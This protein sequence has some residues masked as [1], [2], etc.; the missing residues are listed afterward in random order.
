MSSNSI[1]KISS[2]KHKLLRTIQNFANFRSFSTVAVLRDAPAVLLPTATH[3]SIDRKWASHE[4]F[5]I[6]TNMMTAD[7]IAMIENRATA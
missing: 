6:A 5:K 3:I 1:L 4:A 7:R 2:K